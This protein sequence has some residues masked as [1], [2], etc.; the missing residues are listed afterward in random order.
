MDQELAINDLPRYASWCAKIMGLEEGS[1]HRKTPKEI[2]REYN[3]EK[4][5]TICKIIE[6]EPGIR[7]H[8]LENQLIGNEVIAAYLH[9][10]FVLIPANEERKKLYTFYFEKMKPFFQNAECLVELGSGYGSVI[11]NL[12]RNVHGWEMHAFSGEYTKNGLRAQ[13]QLANN[14]GLDITLGAC[15]FFSM[16]KSDVFNE[17]KNGV[18]FTSWALAYV[19]LL[20]SSL[21][22]FFAGFHPKHV[23][24]FE[25]C[26][27]YYSMETLHGQLC[28]RYMQLNDYNQN[29]VSILR[30]AEKENR[31][32][33][34]HVEENVWGSNPLAPISMIVWTPIY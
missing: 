27:E 10:N 25:P 14:E 34:E 30:E 24:H 6:K 33:I 7:L 17:A 16:T 1:V 5:N 12:L 19:S 11:L 20:T 28:R 4:W 31:I 23:I 2:Q 26:Y 18:V 32:K 15:D 21:I 3:D 8:E 13:A 29:L 22:D 9:N